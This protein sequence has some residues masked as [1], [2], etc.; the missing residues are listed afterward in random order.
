MRLLTILRI[1]FILHLLLLVYL[2]LLYSH[3]FV[4]F[5][6]NWTIFCFWLY[7]VNFENHQIS[8]S[9]VLLGIFY[10]LKFS[11]W[12]R[13]CFSNMDLDFHQIEGKMDFTFLE[14]GWIFVE[15]SSV[16]QSV[17]E[18]LFQVKDINQYHLGRSCIL[19]PFALC[20]AQVL[21]CKH[22]KEAFRHQNH[23]DQHCS[24]R[25]EWIYILVMWNSSLVE[26]EPNDF[27]G[28]S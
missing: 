27:G 23:R 16:G 12:L 18:I 17:G 24:L 21:D 22:S 25:L 7:L 14:K 2:H 1:G 10:V 28:F 5:H 13:S 8:I 19:I 15:H 11:Q 9:E 6:L 20:F 3:K 26:F 4:D